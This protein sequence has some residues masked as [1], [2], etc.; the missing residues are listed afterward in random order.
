MKFQVQVRQAHYAHL[1]AVAIRWG[2]EVAAGAVWPSRLEMPTVW[3]SEQGY[4]PT[5][6]AEQGSVFK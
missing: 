3:S 2:W 6:V 4:L 1:S 5:H